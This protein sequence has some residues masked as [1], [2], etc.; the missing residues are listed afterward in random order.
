MALAISRLC[1]FHNLQCPEFAITRIGNKSTQHQSTR[2]SCNHGPGHELNKMSSNSNNACYCNAN[3]A[4]V[5][6]SIRFPLG[7]AHTLLNVLLFYLLGNLQMFASSTIGNLQHLQSPDFA[8][9]QK[10]K[11]QTTQHKT[12]DV[13]VMPTLPWSLVR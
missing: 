6:K 4:M 7:M 8:I 5:L 13:I 9:K 2:W 10:G 11:T 1:T 12:L 3:I